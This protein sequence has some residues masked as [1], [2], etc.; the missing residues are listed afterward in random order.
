ME[1]YEKF[2]QSCSMPLSEGEE[3]GTEAGGAK[4]KE[5]C[6][7]C[8][9]EGA[10]TDPNMTLDRMKEILDETVG[11]EGFMGKIKAWMG[12]GMLASLKRWKS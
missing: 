4:S 1:T 11:Q 3:S 2:C 7:F 10:F 12:K 6:K 9:K 8:F 5:Y